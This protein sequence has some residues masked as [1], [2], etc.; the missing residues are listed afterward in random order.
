MIKYNRKVKNN[1][2]VYQCEGHSLV[3]GQSL[4]PLRAFVITC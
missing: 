3:K 1:R 4:K 2:Q